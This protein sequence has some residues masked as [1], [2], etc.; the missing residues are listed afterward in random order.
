[1]FSIRT[2]KQF[3]KDDISKIENYEQAL[4]DKEHHYICHHRLE[5]TL[6]GENAH[7][8]ED[9]IRMG[10]YWK[11]PY[12]ELIFLTN[13]EHQKVHGGINKARPMSLEIRKKMSSAKIG[14][15]SPRKGVKLSDE[16]KAKL[17]AANLGKK[18]TE[19]ERKKISEANKL[20]WAKYRAS[21]EV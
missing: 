15:T 9:L 7:S 5:M 11:R 14:K 17:R 12:Y 6:D 1:M 4:N 10:M 2:A 13:E 8:K 16:T 18:H 21:K 20:R 3:C 19:E